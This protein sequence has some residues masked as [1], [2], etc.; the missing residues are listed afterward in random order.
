MEKD[1]NLE[2]M[3]CKTDNK[4]IIE[5]V[6]Y[7]IMSSNKKITSRVFPQYIRYSYNDKVIALLYFKGRFTISNELVLGLNI[8]DKPK[9]DGIKDAKYMKD[10]NLKF[11]IK[12]TEKTYSEKEIS[13]LIKLTL[14]KLQ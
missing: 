8:D 12:I 9:I 11:S 7:A 4:E 10:N 1:K 13:N 3:I 5:K 14:K 6:H 2:S